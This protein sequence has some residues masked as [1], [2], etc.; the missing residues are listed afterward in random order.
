MGKGYGES[1]L[2]HFHNEKWVVIDSF[3][4]STSGKQIA[5][6]YFEDN[7]LNPD[8]IV[9]IICTHWDNDHVAGITQVIETVNSTIPVCI[10]S[11]LS[12][13]RIMEYI[14]FLKGEQNNQTG[15]FLKILDLYTE[16]KCLL[17]HVM[18]DRELLGKELNDPSI[19]IRALSP[20]DKQFEKFIN[21]IVL[22]KAGESG[23]KSLPS[24]N[25]LSIVTF[26]NSCVDNMI[27][28]GD[29]EN[30]NQDGWDAI[31]DSYYE[32]KCHVFKIPHHGSENAYNDNVWNTV[33]DK[34]I[35]LITRFNRSY[36][37]TDEMVNR[38][39]E[40]SQ[41]VYIIGN[42]PTKDRQTMNEIKKYDKSSSVHSIVMM[43]AK[44]GY[45]KLTKGSEEESWRVEPFGAVEVV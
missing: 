31:C 42:K 45:V 39:K 27:F 43:D 5:L 37:P 29:L 35:S 8:N 26:V 9:G 22:P 24:E 34:P 12:D 21:C 19:H 4:D 30:S 18:V 36:L 7:G 40:Q 10:P 6:Q 23:Y 25:K 16:D 17:K 2:I 20:S 41:S 32:D 3:I 44:C 15:E 13:K 1:I 14:S 33:V 28:G 38:I 11:L